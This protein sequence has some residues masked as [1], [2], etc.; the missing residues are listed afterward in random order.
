MSAAERA[1]IDGYLDSFFDERDDPRRRVLPGL[2]AEPWPDPA[3]VPGLAL[4]EENFETIRAEVT[5]LP[6]NAFHPEAEAI[7]RSGRWDVIFLYARGVRRQ[8]NCAKLPATMRV[9]DQL[10]I[11]D[12][13]EGLTYC[14][15]LAPGTRIGGHRGPT[16]LR[17]RC[18]LPLR[19]PAGDCAIEVGGT[20]RRWAEGRCLLFDDSFEHQAWNYGDGDR[21]VLVVDVWHPDLTPLEIRVLREL[22]RYAGAHAEDLHQF[23]TDHPRTG[24]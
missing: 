15:R 13:F 2:R 23:W 3:V 6:G 19:V 8:D 21:I 1:R 14:S 22:Q 12:T 17:L 7:D 20:T 9:L 16:N 18:H 5:A 11:V 10:P 24:T 4:L